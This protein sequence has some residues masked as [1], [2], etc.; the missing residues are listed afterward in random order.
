MLIGRGM[1]LGGH[2]AQYSTLNST[3]APSYPAALERWGRRGGETGGV[4]R[5]KGEREEEGRTRTLGLGSCLTMGGGVGVAREGFVVLC[6]VL[7]EEV[8]CKDVL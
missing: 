8:F 5:S 3:V 1:Y 7:R 6:T 4:K 2:P